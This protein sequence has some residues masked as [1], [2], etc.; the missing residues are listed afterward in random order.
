MLNGFSVSFFSANMCCKSAW[1]FR[2]PN[3]CPATPT[4]LN[5]FISITTQV[6]SKAKVPPG[7]PPI[8]YWYVERRAVFDDVVDR[9]GIGSIVAQEPRIVGLEGQS[10]AGKST[11]ASMFTTHAEVLRHFDKGVVWFPVGQRQGDMES[12]RNLMFGLATKVWEMLG[13]TL[14]APGVGT[15]GVKDGVAYLRDVVP[16][17]I[18]QRF[19]VVADDVWD[20][21]VLQQL[22]EAGVWVLYTS[23]DSLLPIAQVS[24]DHLVKND[25]EMLLRRAAD[26][27][28]DQVLPQAAYDL[29]KA[30]NFVVMD[31]AFV[32]SW[33]SMVWRRTKQ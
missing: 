25:A 11:A 20:T 10:G 2:L 13:K 4:T 21:G 6:R 14:G 28:D 7:A 15:E 33:R 27:E 30:C 24:L 9:L 5:I 32:A 16:I 22:R 8:R 29:M 31:L 26:L 18:K 3:V 17:K 19:L 23:R 1:E 12:P